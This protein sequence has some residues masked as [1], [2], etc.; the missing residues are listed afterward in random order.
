MNGTRCRTIRSIVHHSGYLP[1]HL[2]GTVC[3]A[4]ENLGRTLLR[5]DFDSGASLIVLLEDVEIDVAPG[6]ANP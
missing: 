3:Y 1:P 4:M 6:R 5:V 2:A